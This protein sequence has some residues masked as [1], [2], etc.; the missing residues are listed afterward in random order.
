VTFILA[1]KNNHRRKA[2]K[3]GK[4]KHHRFHEKKVVTMLAGTDFMLLDAEEGS[5]KDEK[6]GKITYY[7]RFDVEVPRGC[8]ELSR[9]RTSV[10][11]LD[12][13]LP[14]ELKDL[15]DE[16][17]SVRFDGLAISYISDRGDVYFRA[18]NFTIT[19]GGS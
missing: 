17:S 13:K 5:K 14:A 9:C 1:N 19:K 8:G 6:T 4:K 16:E 2:E 10:K 18:E 15:E 3:N 12:K 11:I 7:I